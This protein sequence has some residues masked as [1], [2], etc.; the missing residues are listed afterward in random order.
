MTV[1]Y[2]QAI[3]SDADMVALGRDLYY[4]EGTPFMILYQTSP[5]KEQRF[6]A[7]KVNNHCA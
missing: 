5:Y 7:A 1:D 2:E 4:P 3:D 6:L